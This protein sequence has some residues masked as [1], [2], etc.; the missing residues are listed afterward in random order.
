MNERAECCVQS[1]TGSRLQRF[2]LT[3][4]ADAAGLD[5]MDE[6]PFDTDTFAGTS[7]GTYKL[8]SRSSTKFE[9]D[10]CSFMGNYRRVGASKSAKSAKARSRTGS[11]GLP[12]KP[13]KSV[14]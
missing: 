5:E 13:T 7:G 3:L 12:G 6:N 14:R 8:H 4:F 10:Y 2:T 11:V 9:G 1:L